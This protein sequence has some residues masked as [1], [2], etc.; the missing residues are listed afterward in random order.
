MEKSLNIRLRNMENQWNCSRNADGFLG[1]QS[2]YFGKTSRIENLVIS[3][4]IHFLKV[5]FNIPSSL[6]LE[7]FC[8]KTTRIENLVTP[9][10]INII[11]DISSHL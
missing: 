5:F 1:K 8:K 6:F 4:F 2:T 7:I 3:Q 11:K 9:H 10:F